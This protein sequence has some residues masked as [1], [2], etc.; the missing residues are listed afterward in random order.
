MNP[1]KFIFREDSNRNFINC[2]F[3]WQLYRKLRLLLNSNIVRLLIQNS[4]NQ[5][6]K[7]I[8]QNSKAILWVTISHMDCIREVDMLSKQKS[9]AAGCG[10]P[11]DVVKN[12]IFFKCLKNS[13]TVNCNQDLSICTWILS[14]KCANNVNLLNENGI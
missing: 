8:I 3:I 6:N 14:H 11:E 9:L 10:I 7:T 4:R 1:R 13:E 5:T 2:Q 12:V